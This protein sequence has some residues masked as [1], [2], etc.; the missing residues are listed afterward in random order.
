MGP[1]DRVLAGPWE[2]SWGRGRALDAAG[3]VLPKISSFFFLLS[4][5]L[6]YSLRACHANRD[7]EYSCTVPPGR[8]NSHGQGHEKVWT[9]CVCC[10]WHSGGCLL[11][12][13]VR[14]SRDFCPICLESWTPPLSGV[15]LQCSPGGKVHAVQVIHR[16]L[17]PVCHMIFSLPSVCIHPR[18]RGLFGPPSCERAAASSV[19]RAVRGVLGG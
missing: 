6:E 12:P 11:R 14:P 8:E 18:S 3:S 15:S 1:C 16:D 19:G 4:R 10:A 9:V 5:S 13:P 7:W 2:G 17:I